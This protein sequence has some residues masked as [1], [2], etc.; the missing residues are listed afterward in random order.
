M[1]SKLPEVMKL[2]LTDIPEM[3]LSQEKIKPLALTIDIQ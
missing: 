1:H 2:G 3:E